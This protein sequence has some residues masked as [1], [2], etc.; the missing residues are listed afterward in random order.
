MIIT[1]SQTHGIEKYSQHSLIVSLD[2]TAELFDTFGKMVE[3]L[4]MC[5]MLVSL[6]PVA[7]T[8]T[9]DI[10]P[11][12]SKEF[13]ENKANIGCGFSLKFVRDMIIKYK[14]MHRREEY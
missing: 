9:S 12:R 6:N 7:V 13:L 3:S 1:C 8:Y 14:Q 5:V 11:V 4:F 10:A 2:N